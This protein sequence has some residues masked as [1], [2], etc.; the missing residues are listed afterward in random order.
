MFRNDKIRFKILT[1]KSTI[2]NTN[3][4][5]K[6]LYVGCTITIFTLRSII[7]EMER[8]NRLKVILAEQE[9]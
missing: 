3:L 1:T 2:L 9:K 4:Y 7:C 6:I 8:I 5:A